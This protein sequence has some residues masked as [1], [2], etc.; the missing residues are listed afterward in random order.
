MEKHM[1]E[2]GCMENSMKKEN[3]NTQPEK[4]NWSSLKMEKD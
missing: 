2:N 4:L 3:K 1:K